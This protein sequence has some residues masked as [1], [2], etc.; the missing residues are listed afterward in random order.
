VGGGIG[1]GFGAG[2]TE[3]VAGAG[4][5]I[6]AAGLTAGAGDGAAA[7][8][9]DVGWVAGAVADTVGLT[10]GFGGVAV[11]GVD[12]V[13]STFSA[14]ASRVPASAS[15]EKRMTTSWRRRFGFTSKSAVRPYPQQHLRWTSNGGCG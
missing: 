1:A 14:I 9:A 7:V 8:C 3:A 12:E 2:V 4:W 11:D 6:G 15:R 10:A 13:A 5:A